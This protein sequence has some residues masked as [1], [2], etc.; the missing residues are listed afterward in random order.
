MSTSLSFQDGVL[1]YD[2]TLPIV[3]YPMVAIHP[4]EE[5]PITIT[6][7]VS[8]RGNLFLYAQVWGVYDRVVF[9]QGDNIFQ[10]E[11]GSVDDIPITVTLNPFPSSGIPMSLVHAPIYIDVVN[12][13]SII[14]A[15]GIYCMLNDA[16]MQVLESNGA[17]GPLLPTP[18]GKLYLVESESGLLL[19]V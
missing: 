10:S 13:R 2:G 5:T 7:K 14:S 15:V 4:K 8:T 1:H 18:D 12:P 3:A 16:D 6:Y 9:Y 11:P 19:S 17:E